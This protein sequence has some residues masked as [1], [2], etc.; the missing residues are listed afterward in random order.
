ML[1]KDLANALRREQAG[2]ELLSGVMADRDLAR[3]DAKGLKAAL[4]LA[5][6]RVRELEKMVEDLGGGARS[7]RPPVQA[8]PALRSFVA[9]PSTSSP[10]S[11]FGRTG[12][13][14]PP[15]GH[16]SAPSP[17]MRGMQ[18]ERSVLGSPLAPARWGGALPRTPYAAGVPEDHGAVTNSLDP[19]VSQETATFKT[20]LNISTLT[21]NSPFL[22]PRSLPPTPMTAM[23]S[24]IYRHHH[25]P[26]SLSLASPRTPYATS[27]AAGRPP[28]A[29]LGAAYTP[30]VYAS[31]T[32]S[33]AWR[34]S[35]PVTL[36][37]RGPR[38][39]ERGGYRRESERECESDWSGSSGY[40]AE[41]S[42][43]AGV[44]GS[45]S[46]GPA[47][48][49]YPPAYHPPPAA[50]SP[51]ADSSASILS[52]GALLRTHGVGG[53]EYDWLG[54]TAR[55]RFE[56]W[57]AEG[58]LEG[59]RAGAEG[60]WEVK[61]T[62]GGGNVDPWDEGEYTEDDAGLEAGEKRGT[63]E[64]RGQAGIQHQ[65]AERTIPH[66]H[67]PTRRPRPTRK[68][69]R[70]AIQ[71]AH[72]RVHPSLRAAHAPRDPLLIRAL[73]APFILIGMAVVYAARIV[74]MVMRL[75][76]YAVLFWEEVREG[77]PGLR[78]ARE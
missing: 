26:S 16:P 12:F 48:Q 76:E 77:P 27:P 78:P 11:S 60:G 67:T 3:E 72:H 4:G 18:G 2:K 69:P 29:R 74:A 54:Q 62:G 20:A 73:R 7:S 64:T 34:H 50:V 5:E 33:R 61:K 23:Q 22:P 65:R 15:S 35:T 13:H 68:H 45:P 71:S 52:K 70:R 41:E 75:W 36:T 8:S 46:P 51:W 24:P 37:R 49:S 25:L 56:R 42:D 63:P 55:Q 43:R 6:E 30:P 28:L 53:G 21:T 1:E 58:E 14:T 31:F 32:A 38:R 44:S 40:R 10:A 17:A 57:V 19:S 66:R 39:W 47:R 9:R 59:P